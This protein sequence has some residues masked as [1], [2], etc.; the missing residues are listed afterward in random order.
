MANLRRGNTPSIELQARVVALI[1]E[2]GPDE[3]GYVLGLLPETVVRIAN[4]EDETFG[5]IRRA[6]NQLKNRM[7]SRRRWVNKKPPVELRTRVAQLI[8][9]HG[10]EETARVLGLTPETVFRIAHNEDVRPVSINLATDRVARIK[11]TGTAR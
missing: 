9:K 6:E 1:E 8:E 2:D 3:A 5:A 10:S 11:P 4:G 7:R